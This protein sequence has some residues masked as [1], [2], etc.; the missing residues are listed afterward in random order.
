MASSRKKQDEKNLKTLRE[1]GAQPQ[2]KYCFDCNQRGPTYVNMTIGSFVCT[3]CSGML[4]GLTPPH[5][6]KSISMATFTSEEIEM[7]KNRGNDYCKSVWLGLYDGNLPGAECRDEQTVKD[8][9][10]DKYERKRYYMDPTQALKNGYTK[11]E[12]VKPL[13]TLVSDP[14]PIKL[15]GNTTEFNRKRPEPG[16]NHSFAVDFDNADIFASNNNNTTTTQETFANFDDNPVFNSN[17]NNASMPTPAFDNFNL[18]QSNKVPAAPPEDKYAALKDLDNALKTQ[19]AVDWNSSG[20]NGSLYSSPTPTGSMYS[21]PSPQ[22]SMFG[23][24]SQGQ[25]M[26]AFQNQDTFSNPFNGMNWGSNGNFG[27]NLANPFREP[28]RVNGFAQN[29]QSMFPVAANGAAWGANPF[30]VGATAN[31]NSNNPFL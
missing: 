3:K 28:V 27:Q 8:F 15:N 26:N 12:K 22:S 24:P 7:L 17:L 9:M 18:A 23:S 16:K 25:Y 4:R 2:N 19:N 5:R 20:S 6:V 13:T 30:K 31:A 14:K 11:T 1:L 10:V 21:S 29:F